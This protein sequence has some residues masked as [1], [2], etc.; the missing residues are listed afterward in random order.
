MTLD[1][2]RS[3][4]SVIDVLDHVL[5]KGIVID[6]W[7]RVSV[8]GIDLISIDA[9]VVVASIDTY[10]TTARGLSRRE[11]VATLSLVDQLRH[12]REQIER[13]RFEAQTRRRA[14]D[15]LREELHDAQAKTITKR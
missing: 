3:G 7:A 10:L 8:A 14:E 4:T 1:R 13:R 6:A 12:V 5:D 2:V 15:R 11:P 9:R